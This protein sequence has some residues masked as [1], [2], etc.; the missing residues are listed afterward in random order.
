MPPAKPMV[1]R[2]L[3]AFVHR[4]LSLILQPRIKIKKVSNVCEAIE[5]DD[6]HEVED[7]WA[8]TQTESNFGESEECCVCLSRFREGEETNI[9][10]CLHK[11]HKEC[12][13]KWFS[14]WKNCPMCRFSM[15]E[16]KFNA[17]ELLT[18]DMVTYFSSFHVTG[19]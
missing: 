6:E 10:P 5:S 17:R 19:F 12:I 4:L 14:V 2:K 18:E 16:E 3:V 1:L 13:E 8:E 15:D 7:C 9:L 11:F